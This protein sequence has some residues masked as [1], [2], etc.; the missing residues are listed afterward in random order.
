MGAYPNSA[1]MQTW[2][3]LFASLLEGYQEISPLSP[4]EIQ[5]LPGILAAIE[6]LFA[7]FSFET[8]AEAAARCNLNVLKW[9]SENK[10]HLPVSI[11]ESYSSLRQNAA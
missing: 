1:K 7:A 5:A 2:L 9:L 8:Q 10:D 3:T 11:L 4:S 6:L